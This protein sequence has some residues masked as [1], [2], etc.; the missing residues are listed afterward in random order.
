VRSARAVALPL[1][2]AVALG[3]C[4]GSAAQPAPETRAATPNRAPKLITARHHATTL[5]LARGREVELRLGTS[6]TAAAKGRSVRLVQIEFLV[7][8]GYTAWYLSAVAPG[9]TLVVGRSGGKP[10]R[11]TLVVPG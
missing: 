11:V 6:A 5:R 2:A 9:R 1:V 7:D 10:F 3:A 8:P 4:G